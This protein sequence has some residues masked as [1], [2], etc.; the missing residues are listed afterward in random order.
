MMALL[1]SDYCSVMVSPSAAFCA[2]TFSYSAKIASLILFL[3][4]ETSG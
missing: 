3:V 2:R 1:L 4:S